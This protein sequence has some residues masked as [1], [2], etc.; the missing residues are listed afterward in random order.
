MGIGVGPQEHVDITYKTFKFSVKYGLK[1]Y[2]SLFGKIFM[3]L[4]ENILINQSDIFKL[5]PTGCKI[6]VHRAGDI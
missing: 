3:E 6:L 1:A 5:P 2:I 4:M